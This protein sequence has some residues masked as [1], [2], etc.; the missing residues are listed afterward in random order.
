LDSYAVAGNLNIGEIIA[1]RDYP[2]AEASRPAYGEQGVRITVAF[3]IV[4]N[5]SGVIT[6]VLIMLTEMKLVPHNHFG[7]SGNIQKHTL[8][9]TIVLAIILAAFFDLGRTASIGAIFYLLINIAIHWGIFRHVKKEFNANAVILGAAIC[10][11]LIVLGAFI[12]LRIQSDI[13]IIFALIFGRLL[14]FGGEYW[15]L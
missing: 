13:L 9:Y 2:L 3:A 6:S 12:W 14:I 1:E 10:I 7:M 15:F 11:D 5:V 8:V 4:A